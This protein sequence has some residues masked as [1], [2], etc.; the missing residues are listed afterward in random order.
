MAKVTQG[1][2]ELRGDLK[3]RMRAP[4]LAT[5]A[6]WGIEPPDRVEFTWDVQS[7][8]ILMYA[9][10]GKWSVSHYVDE[11]HVSPMFFNSFAEMVAQDA[12]VP[13]A[14]PL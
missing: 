11:D 7:Q 14:E 5:I 1:I 3:Y 6:E 8:S 2:E 13:I 12:N 10:W 9:R 4:L